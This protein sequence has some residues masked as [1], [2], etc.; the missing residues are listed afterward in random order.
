MLYYPKFPIVCLSNK[1]TEVS[2][3]KSL[4]ERSER[5]GWLVP[6]IYYVAALV[7][8]C[9]VYGGLL[10]TDFVRFLC[11]PYRTCVNSDNLLLY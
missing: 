6:G 11:V 4:E 1:S 10:I 3:K 7:R 5:E 8:I 9:G 2:A